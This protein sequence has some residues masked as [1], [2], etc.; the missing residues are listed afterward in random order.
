MDV[1]SKR[2]TNSAGHARRG[3]AQRRDQQKIA[4]VEESASRDR[5]SCMQ[6]H[7]LP[8]EGSP[9][10]SLRAKAW[11]ALH[12][13]ARRRELCCSLRAA[14]RF[15]GGGGR[16]ARAIRRLTRAGRR[17]P[18]YASCP[19]KA[20]RPD[21]GV[22][23]PTVC[24]PRHA[25]CCVNGASRAATCERTGRRGHYALTHTWNR[26]VHGTDKYMEPTSACNRR[27]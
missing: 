7:T 24:K 17:L 3:N 18:E 16:I 2:T 23:I 27:T 21:K 12:A 14:H 4:S 6:L 25:R 8:R 9:M 13:Q 22:V 19:G 20:Q 11:R 1:W 5:Y 15:L 26:Q 10:V